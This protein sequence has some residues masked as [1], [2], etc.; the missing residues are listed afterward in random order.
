LSG[1]ASSVLLD[2]NTIERAARAAGEGPILVAFSGGGDSTALLRL[3]LREFRPKHL[4]AAVVDHAVREGSD[5]EAARAAEMAEALGVAAIV[6]RLSWAPET[7]FSQARARRARHVALCTEAKIVEARVIALGHTAD[8]QA[9]TLVMR[10]ARETSWRA[11]AGIAPFAPSPVWPEGRGIVCV[12]PLLGARRA[13]LRDWLRG[14]GAAWIDDPSNENG[15]FERVRARRRLAALQREGFDLERLTHLA[16]LL[17][18]RAAA[19]DVAASAWLAPRLF[20]E[21]G[22]AKLARADWDAAPLAVRERALSALLAAVSGAARES[23]AEGLSARLEAAHFSGLTIGG[24]RIRPGRA[25]YRFGRDPGAVLGRGGAGGPPAVTLAAREKGVWDGRCAVTA[26]P[27]PARI[28]V[29]PADPDRL[30]VH[31]AELSLQW[32]GPERLSHLLFTGP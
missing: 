16:A 9:E 11:L 25:H 14:Q 24:C 15:A 8:D 10:A 1:V 17:R 29:D 23:G 20:W 7:A 21:D 12:R 3:L 19:L 32:L 30:I 4:R 22:A 2:P 18:D 6:R 13:A 26:G 27:A 28:E 31:G 5:A